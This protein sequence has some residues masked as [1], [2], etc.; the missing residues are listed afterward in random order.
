[1]GTPRTFRKRGHFTPFDLNISVETREEAEAL[2]RLFASRE[3][4]PLFR[5]THTT[6]LLELR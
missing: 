6:L 1:M 5:Q 2:L 4:Y 3:D